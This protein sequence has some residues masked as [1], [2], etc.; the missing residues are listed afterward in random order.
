MKRKSGEVTRKATVI[1][2][3]ILQVDTLTGLLMQ[4]LIYNLP[5]GLLDGKL[6]GIAVLQKMKYQQRNHLLQ[7]EEEEKGEKNQ[8]RKSRRRLML[9][10]NQ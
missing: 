10:H 4:G 8:N 9:K 7:R 6:S 1:V 2:L 5:Y 3:V